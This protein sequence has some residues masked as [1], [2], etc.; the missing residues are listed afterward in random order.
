MVSPHCERILRNFEDLINRK[1]I[2]WDFREIR[3]VVMCLAWDMMETS[4]IPF[5]E[6]IRRAWEEVKFKCAEV[7]A[8]I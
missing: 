7:G 4:H 5:R 1:E 8:Y 6:A 3:A 2:C